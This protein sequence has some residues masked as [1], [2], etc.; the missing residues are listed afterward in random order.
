MM[1]IVWLVPSNLVVHREEWVWGGGVVLERFRDK[2]YRFFASWKCRRSWSSIALS[3][4]SYTTSCSCTMSESRLL[5]CS[6]VSGRVAAGS[7]PVGRVPSHRF[8]RF[9]RRPEWIGFRVTRPA[10]HRLGHP[11]ATF[12]MLNVVITVFK[13]RSPFW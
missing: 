8:R 10:L 2:K 11:A 6:G 3:P 12:L 1:F 4:N 9:A 13:T 5:L 7:R